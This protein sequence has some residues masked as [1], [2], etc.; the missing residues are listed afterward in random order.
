MSTE[1]RGL[2]P[3][4][5][6]LVDELLQEQRE[7]SAVE[8]FSQSA[9]AK[10]PW[11]PGT[12]H[13]D[14]IPLTAPR[15]GEQYGFEVDLDRCSGCKGCVTACHALNGL[16]DGESWREVGVLLGEIQ[17][18]VSRCPEDGN[19]VVAW[20]QTVT[21]ACH[22]CVEPACM[23]G[24]P[25]LAY[26]KDPVTGIVRH[27]DDQCI[28]CSYCIMKCPYEVPRFS[29]KRG[30]V[31]KC[32]MCQGRLADGE[33]PACVQAC[34]NEA[35]RITLV[36]REWATITWRKREAATWLPDAPA[37]DYTLPTTRYITQTAR[38]QLA[39]ADHYRNRPAHAHW[40]LMLMLT[41]TQFGMGAMWAG[42]FR[43]GPV[44]TDWNF[45]RAN[46]A[47]LMG[48]LLYIA[49]LG[50]SVFH[51]G[52]PL[53]AWRIWLGWRTSW[54]SREAMALNALLGLAA[55]TA[56]VA[57]VPGSRLG[58]GQER[59]AGSIDGCFPLLRWGLAGL[60]GVGVLTQAMV[61][62]DTR[63]H[64][65]SAAQTLPR[66]LGTV[67]L[68]GVWTST[69]IEPNPANQMALVVILLLKLGMEVRV[70]KHTDT[71]SGRRHQL[72]RSAALIVGPLRLLWGFRLLATA[73]GAGALAFGRGDGA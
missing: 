9:L 68:G 70:L 61:Y 22:H 12:R 20:Q 37:P 48:V 57:T 58:L 25:V 47:A 67:A 55:M 50:A 44:L 29:A 17:E 30:I 4:V 18:P 14:L 52:Q 19:R 71:D 13:R 59:W 28:G 34:P 26:D 7:L 72:Q 2:S 65:W 66:F 43:T 21:T 73:A 62:M 63:R 16:D 53:K 60:I 32:D 42:W 3:G 27:L 56:L 24:C 51:L 35:I 31:R 40:P 54:M 38:P 6:T 23:L 39:A 46:M 64:F 15:P 5:K 8:K 1:F 33:A 10:G 11:T 41:F 36:P 45:G 69:W 49:G